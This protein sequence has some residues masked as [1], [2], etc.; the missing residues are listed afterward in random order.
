V[1]LNLVE[2]DEQE[3]AK[4]WWRENRAPIIS[5]IVL[6]L[7]II[8]GY[9][10]WNGYQKGRAVSASNLYQHMLN[11]DIEGNKLAAL[12]AGKRLI[13]EFDDTPY[14]GKA[15]LVISR[16]NF[17]SKDYETA[18]DNLQWAI[19]NAKQFETR[20][21]AR[22]KLATILMAEEKLDDALEAL[23][24]E[25]MEGFESH[26][27]ELRG[28]IYRM[29]GQPGKARDAYRAA[30]DGLSAGSMYEPVLKMKMD[31]TTTGNDS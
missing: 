25:L 6:G 27:F 26:Y 5:G 20:H 31:A 23:S 9:N 24:V 3:K 29:Q 22:L 21:A 10:W 11:N 19:D 17:E 13:A 2:D 7:A 15:A 14:S 28:D 30:I 4:Q 18:K 1:D 12:D 16:V 8:V